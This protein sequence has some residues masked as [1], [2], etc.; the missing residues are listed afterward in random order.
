MEADSQHQEQS[1]Q[2]PVQNLRN[3]HTI[4]TFGKMVAMMIT[5]YSKSP[6]K[7]MQLVYTLQ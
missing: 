6:D 5:V 7:P 3:F 4:S 2:W 1:Q